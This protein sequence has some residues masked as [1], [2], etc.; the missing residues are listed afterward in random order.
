MLLFFT[1]YAILFVFNT[2]YPRK[3]ALKITPLHENVNLTCIEN[4][5]LHVK[6]VNRILSQKLPEGSID[7]LGVITN[8]RVYVYKFKLKTRYC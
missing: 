1:G 4:Y 5:Q 3:L 6:C 8:L 7:D 2:S